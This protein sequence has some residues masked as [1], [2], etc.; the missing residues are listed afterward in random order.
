MK[1]F[2]EKFKRKFLF[3]CQSIRYFLNQNEEVILFSSQ[4]FIGHFC[5]EEKMI[6]Q[7]KNFE[8]PNYT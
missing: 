8:F 5:F 4:D 7:L 1:R 2:Y 3:D 6:Y